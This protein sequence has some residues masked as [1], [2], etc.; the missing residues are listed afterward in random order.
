[1]EDINC[2]PRHG[3]VAQIH[4]S[5]HAKYHH[6][7]REVVTEEKRIV[8]NKMAE[9]LYECEPTQFCDYVKKV[10]GSENVIP[11]SFDN[12]PGFIGICDLLASKYKDLY[13]S[14]AIKEDDCLSTMT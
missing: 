7:V 5:T 2:L 11:N 9:L 6:A 8:A 13:N 1:M 4:N 12:F 14:V 10:R 3:L